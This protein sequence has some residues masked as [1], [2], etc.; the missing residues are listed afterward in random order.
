MTDNKSFDKNKGVVVVADL[1]ES[2][3][4]IVKENN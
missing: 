1:F 2:V 3:Y 4:M